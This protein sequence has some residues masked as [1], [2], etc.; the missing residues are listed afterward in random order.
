MESLCNTF[1]VMV[2]VMCFELINMINY[3]QRAEI[4]R[5]EHLHV[6]SAG[7]CISIKSLDNVNKAK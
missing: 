6:D 5:A 3:R 7:A 1:T 2:T 4:K